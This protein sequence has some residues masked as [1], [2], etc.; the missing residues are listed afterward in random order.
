MIRV[1]TRRCSGKM[2]S[3]LG[4]FGAWNF[5]IRPL[6]HNTFLRGESVFMGRSLLCLWFCSHHREMMTQCKRTPAVGVP[7]TRLSYWVLKD[8]RRKSSRPHF[9]HIDVLKEDTR[10]EIMEVLSDSNVGQEALEGHSS[11]RTS[12][13]VSQSFKKSLHI[14][15]W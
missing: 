12:L 15:I 9:T 5:A 13:S 7:L 6:S 1:C 14:L 4:V 10:L 11:L 8:G 2:V 3:V